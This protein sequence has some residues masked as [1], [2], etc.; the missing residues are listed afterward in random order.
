[1]ARSVGRHFSIFRGLWAMAVYRRDREEIAKLKRAVTKKVSRIKCVGGVYVSGTPVDPRKSKPLDSMTRKELNAYKDRLRSF[2]ARDVQFVSGAEGRPL[3]RSLWRQY[4]TLEKQVNER[5]R[6][7]GSRFA[8]LPAPYGD[9]TVSEFM[10]MTKPHHPQLVNQSSNSHYYELNRSSS[11]IVS[12][13]KLK[14]LIERTSK[15]LSPG[16]EKRRIREDRKVAIRMAS[17]IGD[18]KMI[19]SIKGL[20]D[21][22]FDGLWRFTRFA[23]HLSANYEHAMARFSSVPTSAIEDALSTAHDE[24]EWAKKNVT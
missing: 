7:S 16:A 9:V 4:K 24:I 20:T 3:D 23:A 21:E 17:E 11:G 8:E 12:N 6:V 19:G 14:E 10:A 22:Q 13:R 2:L 5:N 1:M 18:A 15:K